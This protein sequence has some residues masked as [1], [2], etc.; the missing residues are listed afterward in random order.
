M[1]AFKPTPE[2]EQEIAAFMA[3]RHFKSKPEFARVAVFGYMR[4]NKPGAHHPLTGKRPG[5]PPKKKAGAKHVETGKT[6]PPRFY[7]ALQGTSNAISEV[8]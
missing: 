1:I 5:R 4:S 2:E 6:I 8:T 3:A 7:P